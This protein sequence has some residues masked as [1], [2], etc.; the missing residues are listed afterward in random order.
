MN[1]HVSYPR[2]ILLMCGLIHISLPR[3]SAE[4]INLGSRRE[5]FVDRH[6]IEKLDG[7]QLRLHHPTPRNVAIIHDEPWEGK[8]CCYMTVFQDGPIYRMYYRGLNV[9]YLEGKW[10]QSNE[11]VT[12]YA[13]SDDGIHWRKP[14]LGLF[15]SGNSKQNN[16]VLT[17]A[18]EKHATHN[19][20]P[21][22]DDRP[23]VPTAERYKGVGGVIG[24]LYAYC[25]PDAIHWKKMQEQPILTDGAFDSQNLAFWDSEHQL[26]RVFFRAF[27]NDGRDILTRVSDDFL[28]WREQ[29]WLEYAPGRANEHY[30]N[31]VLP[32]DRAPHIYLGFPTRYLDRGWS[33]SMEALPQLEFRRLRATS[34]QREGTALT[35]GVLMASRDGRNFTVWHESFLRPGLQENNG[36]FYGS[37]Y[38][39]WGLVPTRSFL[40]DAIDE[41]SFYVNEITPDR[42]HS[43]HRRWTI[44]VDGFVS[45]NAPMKGGELVTK[46]I[47]F[48]GQQLELNFATSAAG[49]IRIE[50][51][52]PDGSPI[53][54]FKLEQ[55][56]EIF[57]DTLRRIIPWK[58]NQTLASLSGKPVRLRFVLKDADLYSFRFGPPD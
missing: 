51:Q 54:G 49:S 15:E 30:T 9:E 1:S 6:L 2:L 37:N 41:L 18:N 47:V 27:R 39:S 7:A 31:Q 13:E 24:G 11:Q 50:I 58:D 52:N 42:K 3:L 44:R 28:N 25:S 26:Y 56:P 34:D 12:C 36:W 4:P 10:I 57:G 55:C 20:C 22:R 19:F 35:D 14:K 32:Y 17:F 45:V 29:G 46:P 33:P 53:E 23:G 43:A 5:L 38:Q 48:S 21:F 16:I 40:D 8:G